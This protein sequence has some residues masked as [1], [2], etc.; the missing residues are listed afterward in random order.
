MRKLLAFFV[1]VIISSIPAISLAVGDD[2]LANF[3]VGV[4][5]GT[6][7]ALD[8]KTE[9]TIKGEAKLTVS[10]E[11]YYGNPSFSSVTFNGSL[12]LIDFPD[13]YNSYASGVDLIS[14]GS[15]VM[16][17]GSPYMVTISPTQGAAFASTTGY[18]P[19]TGSLWASIDCNHGKYNITLE[20][21]Q[22]TNKK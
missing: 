17:S 4:W 22:P 10:N 5:N 11:T 1:T 14:N 2:P 13:N 21:Y 3:P 6:Y 18:T 20:V 8:C 12:I 9:N 15:V 16:G 19:D 7:T